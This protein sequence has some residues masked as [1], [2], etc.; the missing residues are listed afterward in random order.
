MKK[1]TFG[2]FLLASALISSSNSKKGDKNV[3]KNLNL[4]YAYVPSQTINIDSNSLSIQSFIILKTE[5]DN[6]D[7]Q[8]FLK[9]LKEKGEIEKYNIAKVDSAK[10]SNA[11]NS[12]D[13]YK[14][15]YH[16]HPAYHH[17]PVVNVSKKGAELFCDWLSEKVNLSLPDGEKLKFRLPSKAEWMVA[18][19]GGLENMIY[20][21]GPFLR[22]SKGLYLYNFLHLDA[23]NITKNENNEYQVV[24]N[25]N[26]FSPKDLNAD[27]LA[28][29]KSYFPN[30][31]GIY[32]MSGNVAEMLSDKDEVIGGSWM[33][34]G[35]DI[36]IESVKPYKEAKNN[37]GFRV[38][39][40]VNND[41]SWLKIK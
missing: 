21:N 32:N 37:I 28:P 17:Y 2:L 29:S 31:Y 6:L 20:P 7:Y 19:K 12:N 24:L 23:G 27:I 4:N 11:K 14:K 30:N 35:Y 1:I 18:A 34:P 16:S 26:S 33:D 5:I 9:E 15:Y 41:Y 22:N 38:V 36:R 3:I 40:T 8:L 10:W 13:A 25:H 39:A